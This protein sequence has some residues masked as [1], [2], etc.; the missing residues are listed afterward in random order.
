MI[1]RFPLM[2][3]IKQLYQWTLGLAE[4]PYGKWGL[5][6]VAFAESSFFPI[7]P[8]ILLIPL[9][10]GKPRSSL[11][12]A[13]ICALG[14][15]LGGMFG[16]FIGYAF[17]E[18]VGRPILEFYHAMKTFEYLV[19]Q[20]QQNAFFIVFTAAFTPIPYKAITITAGV[21][22]IS[23]LPFVLASSIGRS[24][25]FFL[26][27]GLILVFGEKVRTF[28]DKYF[29]WLTIAFTVLLLGGF[30]LLKTIF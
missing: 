27:A 18:T 1:R 22:K 9:C 6:G 26:V 3:L 10:L 7:P 21:A 8:D 15:T 30:L 25:R 11:W 23:F 16:Y 29:E 20:Y 4:K 13:L 17:F 19:T 5:F 28:I 2:K 24:L 14:S 12:I